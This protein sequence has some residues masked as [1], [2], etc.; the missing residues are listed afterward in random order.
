MKNHYTIGQLAKRIGVQTSTLRYYERSKLLVPDGRTD[1]NYRFYSERALE[2]VRFI[3]SAQTAG[4][5]LDDIS[6]L[7]GIRDGVT[8]PCGEVENLIEKRLCEVRKRLKDLR[9]IDRHLKEFLAV[10]RGSEEK[11]S[12]GVLD[13]LTEKSSRP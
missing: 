13:D 9:E 11:E 6:T 12:C 1:G 7:L 5:S 4:F 10:C 3:R 8:E 2:R